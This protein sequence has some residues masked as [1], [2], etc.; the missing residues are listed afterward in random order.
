MRGHHRILC[1]IYVCEVRSRCSGRSQKVRRKRTDRRTF[2]S[3]VHHCRRGSHCRLYSFAMERSVG[4]VTRT[5]AVLHGYR[6]AAVA[7]G[8]QPARSIFETAREY[9]YK[10]RRGE[11]VPLP[12]AR[13]R[14]RSRVR[15]CSSRGPPDSE[16]ITCCH[17]YP[18]KRE[19]FSSASR[20]AELMGLTAPYFIAS[21]HKSR[22]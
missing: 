13:T 3:R 6:V 12:R 7:P 11:P 1:L 21:A 8:R 15:R 9:C 10:P 16:A 14:M 19:N 17:H 4:S 5:R 22:K 18:V 20:Q 2:V